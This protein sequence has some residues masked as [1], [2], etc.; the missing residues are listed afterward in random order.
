MYPGDYSPTMRRLSGAV[1]SVDSLYEFL[2]FSFQLW[3]RISCDY[4]EFV[5]VLQGAVELFY[6][7]FALHNYNYISFISLLHNYILGG[8]E[9]MSC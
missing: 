1:V 3:R 7:L 8:L 5:G 9:F 2:N 4:L 6:I